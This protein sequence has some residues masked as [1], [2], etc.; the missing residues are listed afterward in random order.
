M[1]NLFN[2]SFIS[3]C[4]VIHINCKKYQ[5]DHNFFFSHKIESAKAEIH[6]FENEEKEMMQIEEDLHSAKAV[7]LIL[8]SYYCYLCLQLLNCAILLFPRKG[9]AMKSQ[10][11]RE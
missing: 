10:R 2:G 7:R 1:F 3:L 4:S 6:A 11:M 5:S 8:Y 9:I